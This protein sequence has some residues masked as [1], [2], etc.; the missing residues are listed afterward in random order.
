MMAQPS[1]LERE[2]IW[3]WLGQD[4]VKDVNAP[5]LIMIVHRAEVKRR[6]MINHLE[7]LSAVKEAFPT[8]KYNVIEFV[9]SKYSIR[10]TLRL[11]R[12]SKLVIA[13][14]GAAL[15]F[16]NAMQ[17]NAWYIL[18]YIIYIFIYIHIYI[19]IYIYILS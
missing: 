12:D 17:P 2:F 18:Y 16:I 7:L 1:Y 11:F 6:R 8:P 4:P 19:Y 5:N 9:G 14:N 13:V 3:K 10:E 15:S